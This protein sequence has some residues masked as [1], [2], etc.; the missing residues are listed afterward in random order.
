MSAGLAYRW[1]PADTRGWLRTH[2]AALDASDALAPQVLAQLAQA[3]LLRV[4]VP[5]AL[6]GAGGD[7]RDAT[8]AIA[9]VAR[10]SLAAAFVLWGQRCF[11]DFVLQS[12]NPGPRAHWL[13]ALLD[14]RQAGATGLSNAMKYLSCIEPLQLEAE[15]GAGGWHV[16]GRMHWVTNLHVDGFAVAAAARVA[17]SSAPLIVALDSA[18][19]GVRRSADLDLLALRGSHTAAIDLERAFVPD[20]AVLALD[21]PQFLRAARPHFLAMQCG[22]SVGLAQAALDAAAA[23]MGEARGVLEP[24]LRAAHAALQAAVQAMEQGLA[25]G[26]FVRQPVPL[27]QVRLR[28][29]ALVQE[30]LQL[31]LLAT[32]GRAYLRDRAPDFGRRWSEAAFIPVITPSLTQLQAALAQAGVALEAPA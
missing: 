21:G 3:G 1:V 15:R 32:G 14:G 26:T 13:A 23:H 22:M 19:A 2:A 10:L 20:D 27:F 9:E 11:I 24:R 25:A 29:A 18:S 5:A 7:A 4:G 16:S 17:G 8:Q 30:A 31:E 12:E 28:L 6:G